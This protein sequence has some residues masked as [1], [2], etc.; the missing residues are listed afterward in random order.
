[1]SLLTENIIP[2]DQG[3][4]FGTNA[5]EKEDLMYIK[6]RLLKIEGVDKVLVNF[7]IYPREFTIFTS[8]LMEVKTIEEV[9]KLTGFNAIPN[10][11]I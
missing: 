5:I 7:E 8:K 2:G 3:M 9:V 6:E 11:V 4:L 1:M 10:N